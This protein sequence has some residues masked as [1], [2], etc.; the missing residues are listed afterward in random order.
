MNKRSHLTG[1][2]QAVGVDALWG[3]LHAQPGHVACAVHLVQLDAQQRDPWQ[4]AVWAPGTGS[5]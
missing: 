2:A 5:N 4:F 1:A 3:H